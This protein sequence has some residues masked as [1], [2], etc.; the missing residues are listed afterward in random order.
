MLAVHVHCDVIM[1][2]CLL[3]GIHVICLLGV[4]VHPTIGIT[5][6]MYPYEYDQT[7]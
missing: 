2:S 1:M 5:L 6:I 3:L 4:Y 7:L